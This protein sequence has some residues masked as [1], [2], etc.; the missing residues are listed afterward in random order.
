MAAHFPQL[1]M[2]EKIGA[3]PIRTLEELDQLR[4]TQCRMLMRDCPYK[5]KHQKKQY[6]AYRYKA[7]AGFYSW[8]FDYTCQD[9]GLKNE[10]KTLHFHHIDPTTK[11]FGVM[12]VV[13]LKN[14]IRVFEEILKCVY[15]CEN[16][17]Y[18]RHADMGDVDEEFQTINRRR[19]TMLQ[20]LLGCTD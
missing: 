18:Q 16:C 9:C 12:T 8:L 6:D 10:T 19:H 17:H 1:A 11:S 5:Q 14:Q 13:K 4:H 15:L 20:N 3:K 2:L 7:Y